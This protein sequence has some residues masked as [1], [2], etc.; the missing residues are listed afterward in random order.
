MES[1]LHQPPAAGPSEAIDHDEIAALRAIV[2]G[3]AQS[4]GAAFFPSLVEHLAMAMGVGYAFVAEFDRER[5][6]ARTLAYWG[7]RSIRDNFE[8]DLAGTPCEEVIRSGLC[9]HPRG[10]REKFPGDPGLA[11]M[12]IESYLG[13]PLLDVEGRVLGHLAVF[14]PR[15]LPAEPR[16]LSIFRIWATWRSSTRV[17]SRPS[18]VGCRSSGS[19]PRGPPSSSSGSGS[20]SGSSRASAAIATSTRRR[21]TPMSPSTPK[22]GS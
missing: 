9:H 19:S 4:V 1:S 21:P 15:P 6:R 10:V 20:S 5:M 13:V 11:V 7:D 22:V 3:T 8:F 16:R 17:R 2:E 12:G 14:D 18:R